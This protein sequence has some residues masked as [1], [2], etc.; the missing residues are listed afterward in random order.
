MNAP[1]PGLLRRLTADA[2]RPNHLP[3]VDWLLTYLTAGAPHGEPIMLSLGE[4]WGDTPPQLLQ[5]LRR[6]PAE[7]HGYQ[8]SMYGLPRLR[9]V[10]KEYVA[11]T[12]RLPEGDT[13]EAAVSWT[14]TRSTMRDFALLT[15][16]N[17][18]SEA[19][20]V[21]P[22][23]DYGGF[24]EPLGLR[25]AYVPT[26]P[27]DG[28]LPTAETIRARAS[29]VTDLGMVIVNAQHN[30]TGASWSSDV[31]ESL[32]DVALERGAPLLIDDAY[33][34]FPAPDSHPVS[35]VEL[36]LRRLDGA[37]CPVPWL[38]VRSLGKQFQCNGWA[39]GS[40]LAEPRLLDTLVNDIRPQH[41]FNSGGAAQWAMAEWL[42]DRAA[43]EG[44]LAARRE[45]LAV[46]Q[47]VVAD[48]V[49]VEDDDTPVVYGP[50]APYL[51]Y[52]FGRSA[53]AYGGALGYLQA[54]VREAGVVLSDAWPLA[55]VAQV[56]ESGYV[57]M[58]LGPDLQVLK[59]ACARLDRAGLLG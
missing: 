2:V 23:W 1:A 40:V 32:I 41:T 35:A 51:L 9:R 25:M 57:R 5:A 20:A 45:A 49:G 58:Y 6:A 43:V 30:P 14:G 34:G 22:A 50:A 53:A 56:P 7:A 31:V 24:L 39:I 46:K 37:P 10:I 16:R 29:Q 4:T 48:L 21:A 47:K 28:F 36:L 11:S 59:E 26:R 55:R 8:I 44:Y 33:Y 13:W 12:Q 27:V 3:D 17:P 18:G 15:R 42:E 54:A 19:L 38:A 52:P